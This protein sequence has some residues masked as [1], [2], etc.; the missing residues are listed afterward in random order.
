MRALARILGAW[1]CVMLHATKL[2]RYFAVL[3]LAV[4]AA[5]VIDLV[6]KLTAW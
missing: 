5:L 6:G 2:R 3:V 4:G 1:I